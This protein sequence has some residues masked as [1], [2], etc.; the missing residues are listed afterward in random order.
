MIGHVAKIIS[1]L[2]KIVYVIIVTCI[3]EIMN[4]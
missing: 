3:Y 1:V 4:L 2:N